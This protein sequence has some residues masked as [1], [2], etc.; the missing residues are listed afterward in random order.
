[1][2]S[3]S[4]LYYFFI[5]VNCPSCDA[6]TKFIMLI[7]FH[8]T[9]NIVEFLRVISL[10]YIAF[11]TFCSVS[12]SIGYHWWSF[13]FLFSF[14][15]WYWFVVSKHEYRFQNLSKSGIYAHFFVGFK[16]ICLYWLEMFCYIHLNWS[17]HIDLDLNTIIAMYFR[18]RVI[19]LYARFSK[20]VKQ[21]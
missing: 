16:I 8:G 11:S 3:G 13:F 14:A 4:N 2:I 7:I 10:F 19:L 18:S 5:R 15:I 17:F 9:M 6:P 1:M 20:F 12:I 21:Q